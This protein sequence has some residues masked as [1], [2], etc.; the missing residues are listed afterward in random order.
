VDVRVSLSASKAHDIEALSR[1]HIR[2][3]LANSVHDLLEREVCRERE[4]T[5][6]GFTVVSWGATRE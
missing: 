5:H 6:D 1:H 2:Q 4:V 3:R